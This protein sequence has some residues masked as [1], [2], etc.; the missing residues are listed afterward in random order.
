MRDTIVTASAPEA[1][2]AITAAVTTGLV[3]ETQRRHGLSPTATAAAGRR[4]ATR[5]PTP[6]VSN[7]SDNAV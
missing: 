7:A 3:R 4:S 6:I 5:K 1:G 2:F